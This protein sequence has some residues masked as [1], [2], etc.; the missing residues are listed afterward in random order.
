MPTVV[1]NHERANPP[2]GGGAKPRVSTAGSHASEPGAEEAELPNGEQPRTG[3][4]VARLGR[5]A[6][7]VRTDVSQV[8]A[9]RATEGTLV[10][11]FNDV[12]KGVLMRSRMW[13][14]E[15]LVTGEA[16][17]VAELGTSS[18]SAA[19]RRALRAS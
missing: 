8:G 1:Q 16:T 7:G 6:T 11:Q 12:S 9:G 3:K 13:F 18:L 19:A 17:G 2:R 14:T 5:K 15:M 4:P 10:D